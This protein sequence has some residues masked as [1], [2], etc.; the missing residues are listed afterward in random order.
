MSTVKQTPIGNAG[1]F[2]AKTQYVGETT[3]DNS[4]TSQASPWSPAVSAQ[5]YM[6]T[7]QQRPLVGQVSSL[8]RIQ[9]ESQPGSPGFYAAA[10]P[11]TLADQQ[12]LTTGQTLGLPTSGLW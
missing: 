10:K 2:P 7:G 3:P 11:Q 6:K 8:P 9:T 12:K 1:Y 4:G 5:S